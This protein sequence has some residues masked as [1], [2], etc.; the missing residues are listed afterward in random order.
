MT[1]RWSS[2]ANIPDDLHEA[3]R[4]QQDLQTV[5]VLMLLVSLV[6]EEAHPTRNEYVVV[7]E[8]VWM[9]DY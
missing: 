4:C 6:R 9:M 8:A 7:D 3:E 5:D 2:V 1:I